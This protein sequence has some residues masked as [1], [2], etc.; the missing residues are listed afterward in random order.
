MVLAT[1]CPHCD[2]VFRLQEADLARSRGWVRCG[3]CQE[4][5]DARA[6]LVEPELEPKAGE[7]GE[8]QQPP[9]GPDFGTGAWDM[10]QP[11]AEGHIEEKLRHDAQ[12]ITRAP[13]VVPGALEPTSDASASGETP[14][15]ATAAR[16]PD[17]ARVAADE[18]TFGDVSPVADASNRPAVWHDDGEPRFEPATRDAAEP[19]AAAD[20]GDAANAANAAGVAEPNVAHVAADDGVRHFEVTRELRPAQPKHWA[21][22]IGGTLLALVLLILLA[23]QLTWWQREAV[24]VQWP[25]SQPVFVRACASLGCRVT[26]PRDID[27]LRVEAT[28]LRQ[29]DGPH[30]LELRV[31]LRNRFG[32]ALAYPSIELTLFDAK[33]NVAIRRIL[34]P[35]E[36]VPPGTQ[37]ASGL[38]ARTTQTMVVRLDSGDTVATNFRVQIFYP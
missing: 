31:P 3:H 24:M 33:N 11:A 1:R 2:T 4:A 6:N 34:P 20:A 13:L 26:P 12:S 5:F 29:I 30:R 7:A 35:Q 16:S 25:E 17:E 15:V 21:W 8:A 9:P 27:G 10:W 32:I 28:D 37:I 22:R 23:A 14:A 36:Y 38:P 18:P 19:A